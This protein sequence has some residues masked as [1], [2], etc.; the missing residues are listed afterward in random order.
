MYNYWLKGIKFV[1]AN[2]KDRDEGI[3]Q[4]MNS[5]TY[6]S[7]IKEFNL[8]NIPKGGFDLVLFDKQLKAYLIYNQQKDKPSTLIILVK[9]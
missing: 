8:K 2:R 7:M 4:K 1:I 6:H 3:F 5:N 9:L